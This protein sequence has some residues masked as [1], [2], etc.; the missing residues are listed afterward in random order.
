M[1]RVI[2]RNGGMKSNMS[3]RRFFLNAARCEKKGVGKNPETWPWACAR[4]PTG[5]I[6][7]PF[8][9]GLDPEQPRSN[10]RRAGQQPAFQ[11]EMPAILALFQEALV[12]H[13]FEALLNHIVDRIMTLDDVE[14]C[15]LIPAFEKF[16]EETQGYRSFDVIETLGI[17]EKEQQMKEVCV[18]QSHG[19]GFLLHR[20]GDS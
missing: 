7:H 10:P 5:T 12:P 4:I 9:L 8:V 18:N 3:A 16:D 6:S 14:L 1:V 20:P 2:S 15:A 13:D 17:K 11:A 19:V